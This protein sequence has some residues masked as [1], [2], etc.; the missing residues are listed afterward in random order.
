[1]P[2]TVPSRSSRKCV[3][4]LLTIIYALLVLSPLAPL[5]RQSATGTHA[6]NRECSGDCAID[7]CALESR[8]NHTCCCWQKKQRQDTGHKP[9]AGQQCPTKTVALSPPQKHS[10]SPSKPSPPT[11][12]CCGK[13]P[14]VQT[15]DAV[16]AKPQESSASLPVY[17][18]GCPCGNGKEFASSGGKFELVPFSCTGFNTTPGAPS[19][20]QHD[21][22]RL[23]I[24]HG[25]PPDKPPKI[26]HSA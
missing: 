23:T 13:L 22:Q 1:M 11:A 6:A 15:V 2:Q 3:A 8:V 17:K 4:L 7:G 21:P 25:D 24:R 12:S 10:C 14:I 5:A 20:P 18:C 16:A 9:T 26:N 19:Y